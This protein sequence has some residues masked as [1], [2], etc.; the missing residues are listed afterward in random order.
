M[1]LTVSNQILSFVNN[2]VVDIL[3]H[4]F[5]YTHEMFYPVHSASIRDTMA[6]IMCF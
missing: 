1:Q 4:L 2:A 3:L 6:Q 5:R